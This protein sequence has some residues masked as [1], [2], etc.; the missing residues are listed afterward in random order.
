MESLVFILILAALAIIVIAKSI[1][2]VPQGTEYTVERFGRYTQSLG[3]G[4][5]L[6]TPFVDRIGLKVNMMENVFDIPS[7]DVITKDQLFALSN[8]SM[9]IYLVVSHQSSGQH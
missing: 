5:H 2:I 8:L 9:E 1:T 7:Q 6:I 3:P 4:L